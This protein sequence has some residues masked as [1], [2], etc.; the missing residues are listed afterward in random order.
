MAKKKFELTFSPDLVN[1]PITYVLVKEFD[2]RFN[3]M[4]AEVRENGGRLLIEV[5][6]KPAQISK[7]AA[8]LKGKGVG[9]KELKEFVIKDEERCTNCGMCVSI[10]PA[11]AIEMDRH[12][13]KV[14]FD[15]EKCI[16]CGMCILS[17]PPMAMKL[18]V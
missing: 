11:E 1:E 10:C 13:W 6:G 2:L 17:C 5:E 9:V 14:K 7:G 8:Y 18:K 4:R 12:T 16:A 3:I 15:Q